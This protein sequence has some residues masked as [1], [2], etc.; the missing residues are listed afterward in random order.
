MPAPSVRQD[1]VWARQERQERARKAEQ[2]SSFEQFRRAHLSKTRGEQKQQD[3]IR[4]EAKAQWEAVQAAHAAAEKQER[5]SKGAL[6][7]TILAEM[8]KKQN[9]KRS[10]LARAEE[11]LTARAELRMNAINEHFVSQQKLRRELRRIHS[12]D[13]GRETWRQ[14]EAAQDQSL[15]D[16]KK[17]IRDAAAQRMRAE[18]RRSMESAV[19]AEKEFRRRGEEQLAL[20]QNRRV[21]RL[22]RRR[23]M[24]RES[25]EAG[26]EANIHYLNT[27]GDRLHW[28]PPLF[29]HTLE[30]GDGR[31]PYPMGV[32][33]EP[34]SGGPPES[35]TFQYV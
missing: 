18:D 7:R 35:R 6:R 1:W 16:R 27:H 31:W 2:A 11:Q 20:H 14:W 32:P 30:D 29:T 17:D 22:S 21:E 26:R 33:V 24:R 4:I 12:S 19:A 34:T 23:A 25:A 13:G 10:E 5:S 8:N 28:N 9:A 3:R 15:E